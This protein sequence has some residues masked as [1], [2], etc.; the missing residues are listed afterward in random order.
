MVRVATARSSSGRSK[1]LGLVDHFNETTKNRS[2]T[3]IPLERT[4]ISY[5]LLVFVYVTNFAS[6]CARLLHVVALSVVFRLF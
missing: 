3:D 4:K 6:F 1:P 2:M 5:I